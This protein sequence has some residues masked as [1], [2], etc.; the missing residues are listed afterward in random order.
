MHPR[1]P[2]NTPP[3]FAQLANDHPALKPYL[4]RTHSG[5]TINF[6][7]QAALRCLTKAILE[8]DYHIALTL[9]DDRLCP[10]VP[11]RYSQAFLFPEEVATSLGL[12]IGTGASAIY[13]LLGCSVEPEWQFVATD[14]DSRS[15]QFAHQNVESNSL[16]KRITI[17]A[18]LPDDPIFPSPQERFDRE[19]LG[20]VPSHFAF[21]MCNPPFYGSHEE[22]LESAEAKEYGPNA[23]CTGADNEMVTPGGEVEFVRKM[24]LQSLQ[25]GSYCRWYTSMLGKMSSLRKIVELL[26]DEKIDN[27]AITEFMQGRTRRWA[28]AWSFTD[29]HLPG[30]LARIQ[31]PSLQ[32]IMPVKNAFEYPYPQRSWIDVCHALEGVLTAI[33]G[34]T[35]RQ[36]ELRTTTESPAETMVVTAKADTWSRAA[37]RRKLRADDGAIPD[38][39]HGTAPLLVCKVVV[40][41][42]GP[43]GGSF[44]EF[45]WVRGRNRGLFE[46]FT[47]HIGRK[48]AAA[49]KLP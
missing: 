30:P 39:A 5:V 41:G 14:I 13:P 10:P 21:T 29:I 34:V 33:D 43:E 3:D 8:R 28:I 6:Q 49:L 42:K 15:I 12:D 2:Y 48:V 31:N 36:D 19:A 35:L 24:V 37:R 23:V 27:Y 47:S 17:Q 32:D 11:N 44:V 7:D 16:E 26:K 22:V 18:V 40:S 45:Q 9:P 1:N 38:H 25:L 20:N 4:I 46:S